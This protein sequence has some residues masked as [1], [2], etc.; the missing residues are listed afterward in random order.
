MKVIDLFFLVNLGRER[1]IRRELKQRGYVDCAKDKKLTNA[2][3]VDILHGEKV[4]KYQCE[5]PRKMYVAQLR[6][7]VKGWDNYE[8][9]WCEVL[10]LHKGDYIP[11][12]TFVY[13]KEIER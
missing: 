1:K 13:A 10:Q 2:S 8:F 12:R 9:V 5:R 3:I 7:N 11:K 4:A 6:T